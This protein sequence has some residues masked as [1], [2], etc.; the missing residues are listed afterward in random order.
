M[1]EIIIDLSWSFW[2]A[3][4]RTAMIEP[5]AQDRGSIPKTCLRRMT[6]CT[7]F[8]CALANVA[9]S[10]FP[11]PLAGTLNHQPCAAALQVPYPDTASF[12]P[13]P[14]SLQHASHRHP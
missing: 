5:G 14:T 7:T 3:V 8:I 9:I 12:R 2:L 1:E 4:L 13:R 10:E 11:L 6:G